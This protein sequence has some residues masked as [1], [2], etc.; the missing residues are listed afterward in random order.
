MAKDS[1]YFSHDYN[2]RND[3]KIKRLIRK[4]GMLG[5]GIFW[6]IIEDLY[7][8]GNSLKL[9]FDLYSYEYRVEENIIKSIIMDFDLFKHDKDSFGS[10]S[11]ESRME[12]R[13]GK[14]Q[15]ASE[16]A[17]SKWGTNPTNLLRS[18]RLAEARKKGT[19][20]KAQWEFM[21]GYFGE[22]VKCESK[23]DLV[24][25]HIKPIYQ[26]G[27]DGIDN[28]QPL[29]RKCNSSKGADSTDW[30]P[31]YCERNACEMPA[32]FSKTPAIKESKVNESI[33]KETKEEEKSKEVKEIIEVEAVASPPVVKKEKFSIE[34]FTDPSNLPFTGDEFISK[35]EKLLQT[36]KW[37]NKS[38]SAI[39]ETVAKMQRFNEEFMTRQIQSALVGEWQG[40]FFS[41]T[42]SDFQKFLQ[43]NGKTTFEKKV[44]GMNSTAAMALQLL[45]QKEFDNEH[46]N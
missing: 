46:G 31:A 44:Q 18:E 24:K 22:C 10:S 20:T 42:E 40:L 13:N 29:C 25:D 5:Y 3:E 26:G 41:N 6:S 45:T 9:D 27:S 4:H 34:K 35:W 17:K 39:E 15:K 16:S 1:Y 7:Q 8:N 38:E 30:R 36:K 2:A 43:G 12:I 28:I 11:I 21:K 32:E 23:I 19:H 14:S 33:I 37:R